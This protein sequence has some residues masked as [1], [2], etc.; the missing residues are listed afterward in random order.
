MPKGIKV[1]AGAIILVM[2]GTIMSYFSGVFAQPSGPQI[3]VTST[4]P[5]ELNP[6]FKHGNPSSGG[7]PEATPDQAAAF[8]WQEFIALNWPAGPQAGKPGQRDTA[9]TTVKFGD[10]NYTGPLTWETFRSK[11]EIFPGNV[12]PFKVVPPPGY[13]GPNGDKSFGYDALP[14]YNYNERI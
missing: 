6:P 11:V 10:P 2:I 1:R 8:A 5:S 4:V 3:I 9:S 14:V 7:A 13:P 12:N